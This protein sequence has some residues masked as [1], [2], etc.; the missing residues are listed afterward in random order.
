MYGF[1]KF[2]RS[3]SFVVEE[4]RPQVRTGKQIIVF[5]AVKPPVLDDVTSI[6]H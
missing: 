3:A 6:I 4:N 5:A 2:V 1:E